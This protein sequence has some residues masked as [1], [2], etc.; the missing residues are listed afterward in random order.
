MSLRIPLIATALAVAL[1]APASAKEL[2]RAELCGA[3]G[4]TDV[5]DR[6]TR[7]IVEAGPTRPAPRTAEPYF[8][9]KITVTDPEGRPMDSFDT[10]WLPRSGLLRGA[11]GVW[12]TAPPKTQRELKRLSRGIEPRPAG[13]RPPKEP[14]QPPQGQLP[15]EVMEPPTAPEEERGSDGGG[16]STALVAAPAASL[17]GLAGL[18]GRR[19]R[20][21]REA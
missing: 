10:R 17:L 15:P 14:A 8:V 12:M 11:D 21:S 18:V 19:R 5:T 7:A 20:R 9:M 6:A 16:P 2:E 1:A 13:S 3:A 4:C